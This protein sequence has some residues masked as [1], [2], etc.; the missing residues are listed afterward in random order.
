MAEREDGTVVIGYDGSK[1]SDAAVRAA[2]VVAA[3][4]ALVVHVWEP[5]ASYAVLPPDLAMAP[6]DIRP[7]IE[8]DKALAEGARRVAERGASL[9]REMGLDAD[10][11]AVADEISVART[12]VRLAEARDAIAVVVGSHGH[13]AVREVLLGST[14]RE[15]LQRSPVP[16]VVVRERDGR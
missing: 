3:R 5:D 10:G 8:I 12:L 7:M 9:A 15:L 11:L 13:R 6:I 4:R 2:A 16:V 1:A 14:T